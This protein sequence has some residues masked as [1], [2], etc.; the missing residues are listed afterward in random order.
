MHNIQIPE[1]YHGRRQAGTSRVAEHSHILKCRDTRRRP[2][3]NLQVEPIQLLKVESGQ[4]MAES[5]MVF[6]ATE[7]FKC[8]PRPGPG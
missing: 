3:R 2:G 8:S 5:S 6:G 7:C 1:H 4:Y